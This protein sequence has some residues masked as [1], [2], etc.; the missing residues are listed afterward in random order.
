VLTLLSAFAFVRVNTQTDT[1]AGIGAGMLKQI[2]F[3]IFKH[4]SL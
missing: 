1:R 3:Y 4:L 2:D